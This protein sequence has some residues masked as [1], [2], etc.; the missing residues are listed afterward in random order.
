MDF[1]AQSRLRLAVLIKTGKS[2]S[3]RYLYP[4]FQEPEM[5]PMV[6][7]DKTEVLLSPCA[8]VLTPAV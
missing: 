1:D 3:V 6:I 4:R 2:S 7:K 5:I 8:V